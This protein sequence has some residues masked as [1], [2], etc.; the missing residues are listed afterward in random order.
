MFNKMSKIVGLFLCLFV[1][2]AHAVLTIEIDEGYDNAL[3]IAVVP[4]QLDS[5][6]ALQDDIGLIV[7]ADLKRS[8]H[9][10]PL[11][12]STLPELPAELE[13]VHFDKWRGKNT[14]YLVMGKVVQLPDNSFQ[15]DMHFVDTLRQ[16]TLFSKRWVNLTPKML[17]KIA[18]MISDLVYQEVMGIRGAFSTQIAYVTVQKVGAKRLYTLEVADADGFNSQTILKSYEPIMSP[19]WSP[20]GQ[21]LA[22]V[23]FENGRSEIFVQSVYGNYRK[24]LAGFNG[25]NSAPAWSPD[26]SKLAMTLSKNGNPDIYVMDMATGSM[27]Q[28]TFDRSIETEAAWSKDGEKL[29]FSSDKRGQPQIYEINLRSQAQQRITFEG[30]YNSNADVS[31]DGNALAIVHNRS[32]AFNI[33]ILDLKDNSIRQVSDTFLDESPSFAPNGEMILYAM[34][35]G[36]RGRLAVVSKD[37]KASQVLQ[38]INAEVKEPAWGPFLN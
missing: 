38:V 4:F 15:V 28:L 37:G 30:K 31:P 21:K 7:S 16:K 18:H 5:R 20:D 12:I 34:N 23:S 33:A 11:A 17:R 25:I 36:G 8:G 9:F 29:Y 13:Q 24:K 3:P 27:M 26:G 10:K 14:D 32:G 1:T 6:V 35:R 22:Y 19:S 2:Q